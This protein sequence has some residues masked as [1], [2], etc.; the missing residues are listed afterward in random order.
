MKTTLSI[1]K[2]FSLALLVGLLVMVSCKKSVTNDDGATLLEKFFE[3]NVLN[4]NIIVTLAT[5]N[6]S[7]ITTSYNGWV[8]TMRK[9]TYYDGP[10]EARKNGT[11][12][13]GTWASNEDYSKLSVVLPSTPTELV[14]MA[15]D[16]RFTEKTPTLMKLAPWGSSEPDVLHMVQQ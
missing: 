10:L 9:H 6:G 15:R 3:D 14:F 11:T 12:Y 16:W 7:D 2:Y 13:M 1:K 5:D 8:F 4:K